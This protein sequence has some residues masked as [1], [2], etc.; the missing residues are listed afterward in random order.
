MAAAAA[1]GSALAGFAAGVALAAAGVAAEQATPFSLG[2]SIAVISAVLLARAAGAGERAAYSV[3]GL[4]LLVWWL[5]PFDTST[6]SPA[7]S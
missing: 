5:L 4:V 3:A 7:A 1:S 6:R 2:V